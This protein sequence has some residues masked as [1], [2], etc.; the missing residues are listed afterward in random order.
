LRWPNGPFQVTCVLVAV[1]LT[2]AFSSYPIIG[3]LSGVRPLAS[4]ARLGERSGA[5]V[6]AI[7]RSKKNAGYQFVACDVSA[8]FDEN[9]ISP[10]GMMGGK[11]GPQYGVSLSAIDF[12]TTESMPGPFGKAKGES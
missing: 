5:G 2:A 9:D 8:G 10:I 7:T 6:I 11:G 1:L 12:C 3:G 4:L